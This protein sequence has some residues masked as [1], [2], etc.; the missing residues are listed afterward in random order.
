[1]YNDILDKIVATDLVYSSINC[2]YVRM[3]IYIYISVVSVCGYTRVFRPVYI[4]VKVWRI[5]YRLENYIFPLH[6]MLVH[7]SCTQHA[8]SLHGRID[9]SLLH[10]K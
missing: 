9:P 10:R 6:T 1:M 4:C 5:P 3:Y 8:I 2:M 7:H